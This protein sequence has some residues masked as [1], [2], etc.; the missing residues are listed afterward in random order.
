MWFWG[1]T[2]QK[3]LNGWGKTR[4]TKFFSGRNIA[5]P[6]PPADIATENGRGPC[7]VPYTVHISHPHLAHDLIQ[8]TLGDSQYSVPLIKCPGEIDF[9]REG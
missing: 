5:L 3:T 9:E 6:F 4:G 1:L 7:P 8:G 2:Y